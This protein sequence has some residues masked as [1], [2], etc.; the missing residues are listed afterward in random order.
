MEDIVKNN[1]GNDAGIGDGISVERLV[2]YF[3]E[4]EDYARTARAEAQRDRDYYDGKQLT[5]DEVNVLKKRGQPQIV[6]NRIHSKINYLLGY[7]ASQ[8]MDP[9]AYPRTPQDEDA[10]EACTDALRYVADKTN[11]GQV[12]SQAWENLIIEGVGGL[13]INVVPKGDGDADITATVWEW[14]RIFWDP[15][16]RKHDFSDARYLGGVVWMDYDAVVA[17]EAWP[18]AADVLEKMFDGG[19]DLTFEDRPSWK[20][21]ASG[22][23]RRRVRVV[24]MWHK[25]NNVW[26]WC[27]FT[28]GGKL[29]Y[30]DVPFVDA[31]GKSMCNLLLQSCF[32]DADNNRYGYVRNMIGPQD[33][34]NK[35]RSKALHLLMGK[36]IVMEAGAVEDVDAVKRELGR[37]NGVI[38]VNSGMRF[39]FL[40]NSQE[41]SG[42]INLLMEAKNEIE[43]VGPNAS[44]QGKGPRSASGR[45]ILANQQGG[46][47]EVFRAFDRMRHLKIR[48]YRLIWAIIRQ[49]WTAEKWVRVTDDERNVRFAGLNRP[50][51]MA[52]DMVQQAIR[53]GSPPE[54][55]RAVMQQR[56]AQDPIF[57]QQAQQVVRVE[58]IPAEMDM[59]ITLEEVQ[60]V[61]NVQQEQ[62]EIMSKLAPA[63]VFP[64]DFYIR[65]SALRN[66]RELLEALDKEKADPLKDKARQM[67]LERMAVELE[68]MKAEIL[69]LEAETA[70]KWAR[71]DAMDGQ[72]GQ[73][74]KQ[75]V[76]SPP[77]LPGE[78]PPPE[79]VPPGG[80]PGPMP[81]MEGGVPPG[82]PGMQGPP[83]PMPP[84]GP[85]MPP[86]MPQGAP[87]PDEGQ[88]LMP[89]GMPQGLPPPGAA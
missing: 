77:P 84:P 67:E 60:D 52:D 44:L 14:D 87:P 79:A 16:S 20:Q 18:N 86:G 54:E 82:P 72:L 69:R 34:I 66:K 5:A 56:L 22:G 40:D 4:A 51:T 42:H 73:V 59:D 89:P 17:N 10:A 29:A 23:K 1:S 53:S 32:V 62:F 65:A 57:A 41:L 35:R 24:Q 81:P 58:N 61:A 75:R 8:R 36:P 15:H 28:K 46:Q 25:E 9:R 70:E 50:V 7:E 68:R 85:V 55:A 71:A 39:E 43:A 49:Y 31:D 21:W 74:I 88:R 13:E 38:E 80:Q 26:K 3:E 78:M 64:P 33:E 27:I 45:A 30:G 11:L 19:S 76:L 83:G 12:F 47:T 63:V 48:A 37:S 2:D 6:I